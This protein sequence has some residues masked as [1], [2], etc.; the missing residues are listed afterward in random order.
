LSLLRQPIREQPAEL[1]EQLESRIA[2]V[3]GR[4]AAREKAISDKSWRHPETSEGSIPL[5]G[6]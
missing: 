3:N 5:N 1:E 4:I 2:V 6:D